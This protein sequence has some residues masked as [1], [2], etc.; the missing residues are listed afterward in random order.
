MKS[1]SD[2]SG[3]TGFVGSRLKDA[4]MAHNV[5]EEY[6]SLLP[7]IKL[8]GFIFYFKDKI[9]QGSKKEIRSNKLH[10]F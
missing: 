1:L 8:V 5:K 6:S 7:Q 4:R 10:F 9:I 2:H 3:E